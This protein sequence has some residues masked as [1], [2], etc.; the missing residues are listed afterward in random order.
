MI[1]KGTFLINYFCVLM[2]I[3]I[4]LCIGDIILFPCVYVLLI[5]SFTVKHFTKSLSNI[6]MI[7]IIV[8]MFVCFLETEVGQSLM[9]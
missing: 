7:I 4:F 9:S 1:I 5:L 2:F 8:L 3:I 6:R